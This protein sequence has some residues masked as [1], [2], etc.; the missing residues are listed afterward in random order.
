VQKAKSGAAEIQDLRSALLRDGMAT[1]PLAMQAIAEFRH[2][3][4]SILERVAKARAKAISRIVGN[5]EIEHSS[6]EVDDFL[7]TSADTTL[8]VCTKGSCSFVIQLWW[9]DVGRPPA[10]VRICACIYFDKRATFERV[11]KALQDTFRD[12]F[13]SDDEYRG[14]YLEKSIRQH[15][16]AHLE[17]EL[18]KISDAWIKMLRA[19]NIGR[20]IRSKE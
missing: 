2:E 17:L 4:F 6:E 9:H 15:Q 14:C 19:A 8:S 18:G 16:V 13:K 20:L 7:A 5:A 12:K 3:V 11:D 1:Y 10:S